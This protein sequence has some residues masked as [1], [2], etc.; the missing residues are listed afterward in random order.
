MLYGAVSALLGLVHF[1]VLLAFLIVTLTAIRTRR[2]DAFLPFAIAAS[3][4]LLQTL[5]A[6]VGPLS[7]AHFAAS[8]SSGSG[9]YMTMLSI[10]GAFGTIMSTIA[11]TLLMIGLVKI[12][13]PPQEFSPH[14]APGD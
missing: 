9:G 14:R 12:A 10:L 8:S 6:L 4:F 3:M 2:P 1:F 11:W 5:I 13:S 7:V